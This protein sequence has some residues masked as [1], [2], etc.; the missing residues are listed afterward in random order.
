MRFQYALMRSAVAF[1]TPLTVLHVGAKQTAVASGNRL[2]PS[3][4]LR[5]SLG[6]QTLTDAHFR[7]VPPTPDE[8]EDAIMSVE[9]EIGKVR[10]AVEVGSTLF[11]MD[12]PLRDIA[13]VAGVPESSEM[14]LTIDALELTFDR[15]A[16]LVVR[17]PAALEGI[18]ST[19]PFIA[20]LLILHE[21]MQSLPFSSIIVRCESASPLTECDPD[22]S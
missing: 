17:R 12:G 15:V 10:T 3:T 22:G 20:T 14:L 13:L 19:A 1:N 5:L 4:V 16:A 21:F 6:F 9:R 11:T 7:H 2:E 8:M 18:P